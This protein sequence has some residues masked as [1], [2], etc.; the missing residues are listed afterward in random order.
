MPDQAAGGVNCSFHGAYVLPRRRGNGQTPARSG[1]CRS[2]A[3]RAANPSFTRSLRKLLGT[4]RI[5]T[6]GTTARTPEHSFSWAPPAP[7]PPARGLWKPLAR[8]PLYATQPRESKENLQK[9]DEA[10]SGN[11][12]LLHARHSAAR[13]T[14]RSHFVPDHPI[15]KPRHCVPRTSLRRPNRVVNARASSRKASWI[16]GWERRT[17]IGKGDTLVVDVS[18]LNVWQLV[19]PVGEISKPTVPTSWNRRFTLASRR[20]HRL[21]SGDRRQNHIYAALE[22]R[23]GLLPARKRKTR[24][25]NEFKCVEYAEELIYG[26]LRKKK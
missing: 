24:E 11:P 13:I 16:P 8:F 9:P 15:P 26:D 6:F 22:D 2:P 17:A 14:C 1:F 12:V 5:G 20:S 4:R 18:G 3:C 19:R 21:R 10:R 25:L 23:H 7:S